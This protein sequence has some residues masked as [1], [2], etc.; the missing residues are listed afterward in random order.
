ME[1]AFVCPSDH[2]HGDTSTCHSSHGCR[3][4]A[5]VTA[6]TEYCFW[7]RHMNASGRPLNTPVDATGT[8][9]R[10]HALAAIGWSSSAIAR[11][12]GIDQTAVPRWARRVYV[13]RATHDRVAEL[14]ER[15]S[16]TRPPTSTLGERLSVAKTIAYAQ[17]NG[18]ALPLE[19][20]DIDT[21]LEPHRPEPVDEIDVVA[22]QL[23]VR[24][25]QRVRLSI[26]ERHEAVRQLNAQGRSDGQIAEAL[27][28]NERTVLRDRDELGIPA[29]VGA[30]RQPL[31][32]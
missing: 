24:D 32:A 30:D 14:Y 8:R 20:D 19:W 16:T 28:V 6:H 29:A 7:W 26:A 5:C 21:D 18:Y 27:C 1:D 23:V 17:R 12:L 22:V 3:C 25:G 31:A 13:S 15:L 2:K 9:R 10:L 4:T 11:L